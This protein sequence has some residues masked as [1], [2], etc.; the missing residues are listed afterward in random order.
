MKHHLLSSFSTNKISEI[1]M[2]QDLIILYIIDAVNT[3]NGAITW[4]Q[5]SV[6]LGVTLLAGKCFRVSFEK[7]K[8]A[9]YRSFNAI[10]PNWERLTIQW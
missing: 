10:I 2:L 4:K 6:Y 8:S 9:F 1:T 5:E 7:S 3:P